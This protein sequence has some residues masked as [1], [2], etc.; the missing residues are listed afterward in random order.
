MNFPVFRHGRI[1]SNIRIS[2]KPRKVGVFRVFIGFSVFSC[3]R[4]ARGSQCF[5][6]NVKNRLLIKT[7]KNTEIHDFRHA[8]SNLISK[9]QQILGFDCF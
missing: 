5:A 8:L 1:I 2:A 3:L 4:P 9:V 6:E 7:L